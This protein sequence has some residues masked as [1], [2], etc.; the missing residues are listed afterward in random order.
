[1]PTASRA[2]RPSPAA[3]TAADVTSKPVS[4]ERT[5]GA[6]ECSTGVGVSAL[7]AAGRAQYTAAFWPMPCG[8]IA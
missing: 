1:M 2:M 3:P 7:T 5:C 6:L 4:V 8:R